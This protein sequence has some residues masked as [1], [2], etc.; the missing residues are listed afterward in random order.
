MKQTPPIYQHSVWQWKHRLI[1]RTSPNG[2]NAAATAAA[3][4]LAAP[5]Q[6]YG[7]EDIL[8]ETV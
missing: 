5:P 1:L 6:A 2:K 3:D 4:P 7:L 8:T